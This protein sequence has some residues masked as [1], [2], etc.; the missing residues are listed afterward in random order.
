MSPTP[1]KHKVQ[2]TGPGTLDRSLSLPCSTHVCT[3]SGQSCPGVPAGFPLGL[4]LPEG[5]GL[6][7]FVF[8]R[9]GTG[10]GDILFQ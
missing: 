10:P 4:K 8:P 7:T 6:L 3:G 2:I 9:P 1:I 5:R